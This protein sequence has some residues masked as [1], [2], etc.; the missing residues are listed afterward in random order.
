MAVRE[1]C[2]WKKFIFTI[3]LF[4]VDGLK[5]PGKAPLGFEANRSILFLCWS[6]LL[7]FIDGESKL[8]EPLILVCLP[9]SDQMDDD[10][11]FFFFV[12]PFLILIIPNRYP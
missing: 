8:C 1:I 4:A 7:N 3:F 12:S 9:S 6:C 10:H 11:V 2:V 5:E